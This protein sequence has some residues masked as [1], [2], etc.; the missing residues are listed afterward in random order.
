MTAIQKFKEIYFSKRRDGILKK[1]NVIEHDE[2]IID[3]KIYERIIEKLK[4]E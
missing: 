4:Y 1:H 3:E 2:L